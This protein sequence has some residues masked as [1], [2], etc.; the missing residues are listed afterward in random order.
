MVGVVHRE[1]LATRCKALYP[2][3]V[4]AACADSGGTPPAQLRSDFFD[5]VHGYPLAP[6]PDFGL[7]GRFC[8]TR[9]MLA[10]RHV[11]GFGEHDGDHG[12]PDA[13]HDDEHHDERDDEHDRTRSWV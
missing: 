11:W 8:R 5:R 6:T 13:N 12:E 10:N 3:Y 2:M 7:L 4:H 1:R 9:S